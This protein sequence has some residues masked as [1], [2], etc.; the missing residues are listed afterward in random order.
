M[1]D[2]IKISD[3]ALSELQHILDSFTEEF[4]KFSVEQVNTVPYEDSWTPGQVAEHVNMSVSGFND[5]LNGPVKDTDRPYDAMVADLKKYFLDYSIK[6]QSP[7][8]VIPEAKNYGKASLLHALNSSFTNIVH[9]AKTL[10]AD[11]TCTG[12]ELPVLGYLT[13][14]EAIA[15]VTYHTQRHIHQ[16]KKMNRAFAGEPIEANA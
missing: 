13:R 3:E 4:S 7:D 5:M 1:K 12:F 11:K 14:L 9:S 15:F 16:L 8:F 2:Q 10:A 6:M